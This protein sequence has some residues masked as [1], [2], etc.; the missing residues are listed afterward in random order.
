[1]FTLNICKY[2]ILFSQK[3][4]ITIFVKDRLDM[5]SVTTRPGFKELVFKIPRLEFSRMRTYVTN[6][7]YL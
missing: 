6:M 5:Q 3:G 1:M 4:E 2:A 7:I